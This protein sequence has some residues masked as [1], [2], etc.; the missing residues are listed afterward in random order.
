MRFA[1]IVFNV[2]GIYG[3]LVLLP[4]YFM[5]AKIGQNHPPA[6]TH[7]EFF[8]AFVSVGLA[9]QIAF[10][11][12]ARDPV[13]YRLIML[14]GIVEKWGF[15]ASGIT[16]LALGRVASSFAIP[17]A[18]DLILGALFLWAFFKTPQERMP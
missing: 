5:E 8:Y 3:V 16:L 18:S 1:K 6:I 10:L 13:R 4:H 7:P 11:I 14:P 12:I 9:W 2:A 15:A 17:I